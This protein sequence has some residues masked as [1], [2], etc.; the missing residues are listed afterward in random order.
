MRVSACTDPA[1]PGGDNEDWVWASPGRIVV[2]D[3]ATARTDTGCHHGV[4]W[5]A[6]LL[7]S[8]LSTLAS[9]RD[10]PLATALRLAITHVMQQHSECDLSHPGTPSAAVAVVRTGEDVLEYLVL[11]DISVVLEGTD[12]IQVITD[13][14]VDHTARAEREGADRYLIGS[15]DKQAALVRLKHAELAA[16]NQSGGYWVAAADPNVVTEA[17]TGKLTL[18]GLRRVAMLSDGGARIVR[19]FDLMG[20][21]ELLDLLDK[22]GPG[23]VIRRIRAVEAADPEG[24]R[25]SRNKASDDATIVYAP[26]A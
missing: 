17:L 7:G 23:E 4:A 18:D 10:T 12:G 24:Q 14:R 3:G 2:L 13:D 26:F 8:A 15:A 11:G 1:T 6:T 5:Y 9:N 19:P 22:A 16:R 20:W 25:W 21:A